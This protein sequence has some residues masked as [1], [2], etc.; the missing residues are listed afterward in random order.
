MAPAAN[1]E[2]KQRPGS[3]SFDAEGNFTVM[4][5][6]P[7]DG[8]VPGS[9]QISVLC[10]ESDPPPVP[11]GFESVSYVAPEYKGQTLTIEAGSA[12]VELTIDVP[13]KKR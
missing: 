7:G 5:F 3:A 11:G 6:E 12:P 8:L 4:S 10:V 2:T 9:Y 1:A 13:L